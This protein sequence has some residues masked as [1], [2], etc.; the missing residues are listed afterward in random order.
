MTSWKVGTGSSPSKAVFCGRTLGRRSLARSVRS[1]ASVKSSV[2]QPVM[3]LPSITLV[4]LRLA[5]SGWSATSVVAV[6]SFSCRATRTWSLVETRSG[7]M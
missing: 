7:S 3:G 6:M 5:N 4:V 2:N 1:S